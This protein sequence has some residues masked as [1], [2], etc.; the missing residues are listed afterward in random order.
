MDCFVFL[1][2]PKRQKLIFEA[3]VGKNIARNLLLCAVFCV[4]LLLCNGALTQ[5]RPVI[6]V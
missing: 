6:S 2:G 3:A 1:L 4:F 5:L